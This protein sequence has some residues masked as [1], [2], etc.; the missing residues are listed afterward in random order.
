MAAQFTTALTICQQAKYSSG[1]NDSTMTAP[2]TCPTW[3]LLLQAASRVEARFE[4][5]LADHGLSIPK[6]AALKH[7]AGAEEPMP[8]GR[9][10]ERMACVKS[11]I[12]QLV[13]RLESEGLVA[14]VADSA[15]RRCVRASITDE[16]RRRLEVG[17]TAVAALEGEIFGVLDPA[18][19]DRILAFLTAVAAPC[20]S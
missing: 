16:G 9:L 6:L 12:T 19:R 5:A 8:L 18:D 2:V 7:L 11:N 20:G 10:A 13:D 17:A 14:R 1:V 15:D 3:V 4:T